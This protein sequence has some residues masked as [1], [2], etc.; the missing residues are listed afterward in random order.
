MCIYCVRIAAKAEPWFNL[1]GHICIKWVDT[2]SM[3]CYVMLRSFLFF[4]LPVCTA[5]SLKVILL[6]LK[7]SSLLCIYSS[8]WYHSQIGGKFDGFDIAK[9]GFDVDS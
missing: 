1:R 8:H 4:P 6:L 9:S 7:D 3:L 2:T 5:R